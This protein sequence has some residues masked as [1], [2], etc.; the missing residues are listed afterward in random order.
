[1][2][3]GHFATPR[4]DP[5]PLGC[6][7]GDT[8]AAAGRGRGRGPS[9]TTGC[10]A[11][12]GTQCG[13]VRRGQEGRGHPV[14]TS[15]LTAPPVPRAPRNS[16]LRLFQVLCAP[17]ALRVL[18]PAA[19]A[20]PGGALPAAACPRAA[21]TRRSWLGRA[22]VGWER[23]PLSPHRCGRAGCGSKAPRPAGPVLLGGRSLPRRSQPRGGRAHPVITP[24]Q[25][26]ALPGQRGDGRAGTA[27]WGPGLP[28]A[29]AHPLLAISCASGGVCAPSLLGHPRAPSM[30]PTR[31]G[32]SRGQTQQLLRTC[33]AGPQRTMTPLRSRGAGGGGHPRWW[34]QK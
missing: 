3:G 26:P 12:Q 32:G 6:P 20:W 11:G 1:M 33:P 31:G 30:P 34:W 29:I 7:A 8:G 9:A 25:L 16:E 28:E 14:G 23:G 15:G 18:P 5:A 22:G 10:G 17:P 21:G 2:G 4:Q 27:R 19:P 13:E 24:Q